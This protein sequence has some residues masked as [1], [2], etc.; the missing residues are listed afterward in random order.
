MRGRVCTENRQKYVST[1]CDILRN[2]HIVP[3]RETT[4]N[5]WNGKK[6]FVSSRRYSHKTRVRDDSVSVW[7]SINRFFFIFRNNTVFFSSFTSRLWDNQMEK[8]SATPGSRVETFINRCSPIK[9]ARNMWIVSR[10]LFAA[11]EINFINK[12][13]RVYADNDNVKSRRE[14]YARGAHEHFG[15]LAR[16]Y[17]HRPRPPRR[18]LATWATRKNCVVFRRTG[19]D[20]IENGREVVL[21]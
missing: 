1:V 16:T 15:H 9:D 6:T 17:F 8:K 4:L 12:Y 18:T 10:T 7:L 20:N 2:Y 5:I 3:R 21:P 19:V 13:T 11:T 14:R